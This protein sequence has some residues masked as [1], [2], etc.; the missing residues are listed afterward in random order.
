MSRNEEQE[1]V[2]DNRRLI[3]NMA[4]E[5]RRDP[6]MEVVVLPKAVQIV[7][8]SIGF[9]VEV[10]C[11]SFAIENKEDLLFYLSKY[12]EHPAQVEE[13]VTRTRTLR[14]LLKQ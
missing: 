5:A 8:L 1:M 14:S 6:P 11:M 7:P 4:E 10:G 2:V 3:R 9:H 12:L 13:T